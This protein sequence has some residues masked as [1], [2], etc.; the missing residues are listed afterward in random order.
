VGD[1]APLPNPP[2]VLKT[3]AD[4]VKNLMCSVSKILK[5]MEAADIIKRKNKAI[6]KNWI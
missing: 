1:R 4:I 3:L 2:K 6:M 5:V